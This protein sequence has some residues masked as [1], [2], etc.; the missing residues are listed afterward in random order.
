M[1]ETVV[2]LPGIGERHVGPVAPDD[3][4]SPRLAPQLQHDRLRRIGRVEPDVDDEFTLLG[5]RERLIAIRRHH[6]HR[7]G[8]HDIEAAEAGVRR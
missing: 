1:H 8:G 7:P 6:L 4:V 2:G 3:A 5:N